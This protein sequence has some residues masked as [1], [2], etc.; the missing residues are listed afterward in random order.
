MIM[1]RAIESRQ[2]S[3]SA[4]WQCTG[5]I[6]LTTGASG[7]PPGSARPTDGGAVC[8][9]QVSDD[10]PAEDAPTFSLRDWLAG[11]AGGGE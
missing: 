6:T 5:M 10:I 11:L 4:R 2:A 7:T 1:A 8:N 9:I 3:V